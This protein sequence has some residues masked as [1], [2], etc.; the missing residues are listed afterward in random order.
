MGQTWWVI[1]LSR[2]NASTGLLNSVGSSSTPCTMKCSRP[3]WLTGR[4]EAPL[5]PAPPPAGVTAACAAV[6]NRLAV[7]AV[8]DAGLG[9][10]TAVNDGGATDEPEVAAAAA[11][12]AAVA[13]AAADPA[14]VAGLRSGRSH[15]D[16][17]S[18]ESTAET[19]R[20]S[21]ILLPSSSLPCG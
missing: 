1:Y 17:R 8:G 16:A 7:C 6:G 12:T 15:K 4:E 9:T 13:A 18:S 19:S 3:T 14:E 11:T 21:S 2:K 20:D 5:C 10:H